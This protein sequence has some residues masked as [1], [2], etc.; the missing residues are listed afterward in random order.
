MSVNFED[1]YMIFFLK[2]A[3]QFPLK[4]GLVNVELGSTK[5]FFWGGIYN[6][7]MKIIMLIALGGRHRVALPAERLE[8]GS[9]RG[10]TECRP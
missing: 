10:V 6:H 2:C 3:G 5:K 8:M 1:N 4:F 9:R 7:E